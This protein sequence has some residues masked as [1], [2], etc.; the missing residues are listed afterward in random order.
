VAGLIHV[1]AWDGREYLRHK[2]PLLLIEPQ[3]EPFARLEANFAGRDDVEFENVA[4]GDRNGMA[5]MHTAS[6]SHSSSLLP[7]QQSG[8]DITFAGTERVTLMT[9]DEVMRGRKGFDQLVIDTQGY[10]LE[11]LKGARETLKGIRRV[12]CEIH[13][14]V[15]YPGAGSL[16][17]IDRYLFRLGFARVSMDTASSDDLADVVYERTE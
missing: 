12:E 14:P 15:V 9:L 11:V 6:P 2:G 13:D 5:T 10:E 8:D 16:E 4:I 17:E 7:P 3:A 1:G